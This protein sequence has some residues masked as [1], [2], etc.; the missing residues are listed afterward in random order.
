[1]TTTGNDPIPLSTYLKSI[2]NQSAA[3]PGTICLGATTVREIEKQFFFIDQIGTSYT[4]GPVLNLSELEANV[5][6]VTG[7]QLAFNADGVL[8]V[9]TIRAEKSA[10]EELDD[11]I[12]KCDHPE[13]IAFPGREGTFSIGDIEISLTTEA[14]SSNVI[15]SFC[16]SEFLQ[17]KAAARH[18]Q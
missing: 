13:P 4:E 1:M 5:Q 9:A 6:G 18:A 10:I 7:I 11:V 15:I 17:A 12:L 3:R 2:T 14:H 16:T 8:D